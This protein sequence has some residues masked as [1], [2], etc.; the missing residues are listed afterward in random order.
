MIEDLDPDISHFEFFLSKTSLSKY[1]WSDDSELLSASGQISSCIWGWPGNNLLDCDMT[2]VQL[3][4]DEWHFLNV[5]QDA[6]SKAT[7][8]SLALAW[9]LNKIAS[10]ARDLQRKRLLLL[11]S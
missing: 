11:S 7:V 9:D 2:P 8:G 1:S 5:L 3:S 10:V 4:S 6:P